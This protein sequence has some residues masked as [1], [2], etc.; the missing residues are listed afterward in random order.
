MIEFKNVTKAF[1]ENTVLQNVSFTVSDSS[2]YGLVG[3]NGAGKTTLLKTAA[4]IYKPDGGSVLFN[5]INTYDSDEGRSRLF[6]MPDN[7]FYI[8]GSTAEAMA[9]FYQ[10]MYKS[11]D[12]K[13]FLKISGI[14]GFDIK[15]K[16]S[17]FSKGMLKQAEIAFA[18]A[19]R[20]EQLLL[21]EVFD[22]LDPQKK[23]FFRQ[24]ILEYIIE[25]PC[26]VI[27]SSHSIA[28][29]SGLCDRIGLLNGKSIAF[30]CVVDDIPLYNKNYRILLSDTASKDVLS[31]LPVRSLKIQGNAVTFSVLGK[32]NLRSVEAFLT[33]Y[34]VVSADCTPMTAE[35]IFLSETEDKSN[36]IRKLFS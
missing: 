34:E 16:L 26:S 10:K 23:E 2:I 13:L 15:K 1:E 8:R 30:D 24:I 21:D 4:G 31:R 33:S 9:G 35:E 3:F 32:D 7:I 19:S 22:G 12:W 11:F 20:P 18:V 29:L 6:F 14:F 27:V 25:S 17:S 28:D 36:E 5:G